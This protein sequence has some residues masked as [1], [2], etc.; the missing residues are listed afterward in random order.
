M[1]ILA[2]QSASR[3]VTI[4]TWLEEVAKASFSLSL[5]G[6]LLFGS[7][8]LLY[9]VGGFLGMMTGLFML[10]YPFLS[11]HA[12]PLFNVLAAST[13]ILICVTTSTLIFL[14]AFTSYQNQNYDI[15]MFFSFIGFGFGAGA[16]RFTAPTVV[17]I[18]V[19][20]L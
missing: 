10:P 20:L 17:S 12:D 18:L 9:V 7:L 15:V 6:L 19:G 13:G 11:L 4:M 14:T 16:I 2:V 1:T 5:N 3:A 8:F